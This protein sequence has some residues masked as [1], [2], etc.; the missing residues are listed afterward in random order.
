[1]LGISVINLIYQMIN[2]IRQW[3]YEPEVRGVSVND[4]QLLLVHRKIVLS[5]QLLRSSFKTFYKDMGLLCDKFFLVHGLEIE[6]GSGAGFF[7]KYR[8]SI[9]TSDVRNSVD[10]DLELNALDMKLKSNTVRCIY[11]INVFHHLPEPD[12]F[13]NELQRVL[14]PGGGCILIEPHNGFFSRLIHTHLHSDEHFDVDADG[15]VT[16]QISGPLSGAN[17]ALAHIVF[18]RDFAKFSSKYGNIFEIVYRGYELNGLRYLLS[19]GVNFRQLFPSILDGPLTYL[20]KLLSS[21]ARYWTLHQIIVI[22]RI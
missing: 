1:M 10:F 18:S 13:F 17:Q 7:K 8:D 14:K 22:R 11:A 19:G 21:I 4:D 15:W 5:K 12:L 20:E 3:L 16:R 6:L 2:K 9:I